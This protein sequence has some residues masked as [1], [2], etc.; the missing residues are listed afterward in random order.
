MKEKNQYFYDTHVHTANYSLCAKSF[1]EEVIDSAIKKNI[2]VLIITDHHKIFPVE[3]LS[4]DRDKIL[5]LSGQEVTVYEG[6]DILIYGLDYAIEKYIPLK[7]LI[8]IIEE[9]KDRILSILAHP[10]RFGAPL[11]KY[12]K[13]LSNILDGVEVYNGNC[14]QEEN[15]MAFEMA[16]KYGYKNMV[17]GSDAHRAIDVGRLLNCSDKKVTNLEEFIKLVKEGNLSF[18]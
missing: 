3:K 1:V 13:L 2:D 11:F 7:K 18:C 4:Y 6:G 8:E 10:F 12:F 5:V 17:A 16:R 14:T 15:D 9:N